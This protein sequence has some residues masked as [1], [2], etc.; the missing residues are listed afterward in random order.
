MDLGW[1]RERVVQALAL[2]SSEISLDMPSGE[3]DGGV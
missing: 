1:N 3:Q 2:Q